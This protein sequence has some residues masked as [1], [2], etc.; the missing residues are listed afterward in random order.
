MKKRTLL[1]ALVFSSGTLLAFAAHD[2]PP[3]GKPPATDAAP[4]KSAYPL[5]TCVVSGEDLG[6]DMGDAVDY[7][8]KQDGQPD[9]LV[10]LCCE[11]CVPKFEKDPAK[12]LKLIDDAAAAAKARKN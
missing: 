9:R 10:R 4:A 11:K 2:R 1:L 12:Y 5:T 8:Y 6:G 7:T 3:A